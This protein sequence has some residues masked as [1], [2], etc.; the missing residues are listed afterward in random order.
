MTEFTK[1]QIIKNP[2]LKKNQS[3]NDLIQYNCTLESKRQQSSI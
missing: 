1:C 2:N 3:K